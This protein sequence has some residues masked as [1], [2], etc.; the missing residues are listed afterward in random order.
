MSNKVHL[1]E[2]LER[3]LAAPAA[4]FASVA[5]VMGMTEDEV[6]KAVGAEVPPP[7]TPPKKKARGKAIT[8]RVGITAL[9]RAAKPGQHFFTSHLD[10]DVTSVAWGLG[11]SVRTS[12][13]KAID[14]N[15]KVVHLVQVFVD[16]NAGSPFPSTENGSEDAATHSGSIDSEI[17][18]INADGD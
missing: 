18:N 5:R 1:K 9:L 11:I 4:T 6:R 2:F 17:K 10:R 3:Y 15:D 7:E 8:D 16:D 12:R 13:L 14:I